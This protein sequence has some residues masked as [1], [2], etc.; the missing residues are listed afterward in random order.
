M[1]SATY[2]AQTYTFLRMVGLRDTGNPKASAV[3]CP[4]MT[5]GRHSLAHKL[6][7]ITRTATR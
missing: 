2:Y 5:N 7:S 6:T 4:L 1:S 3:R